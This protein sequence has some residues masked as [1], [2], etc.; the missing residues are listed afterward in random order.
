[1][2]MYMNFNWWRKGMAVG[3]LFIAGF[4]S[5]ATS[6][7]QVCPWEFAFNTFEKVDLVLDYTSPTKI[8]SVSI[9]VDTDNPPLDS[10]V[11]FSEVLIW[12]NLAWEQPSEQSNSTTIEIVP[13]VD[14]LEIEPG[15]FDESVSLSAELLESDWS[16]YFSLPYSEQWPSE[17][18][19]TIEF[20]WPFPEA[21]ERVVIQWGIIASV[22]DNLICEESEGTTV[23]IV[24]E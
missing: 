19:L 2:A 10:D 21:G 22:G 1:M 15:S 11:F 9:V 13:K 23:D 12:A 4:A 7:L 17:Q 8:Y 3:M 20:S 24:V 14:G 5:M 18:T 16:L 6:E